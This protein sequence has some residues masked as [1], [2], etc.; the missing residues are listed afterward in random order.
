MGA[1]Y[2]RT[3]TLVKV[4]T[5]MSLH[6]LSYNLKRVTIASWAPSSRICAF[7]TAS[8]NRIFGQN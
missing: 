3:E 5:E 6:V 4:R 2:F 1:T 7:Y 8:T